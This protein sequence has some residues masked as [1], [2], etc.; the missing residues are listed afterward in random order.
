MWERSV[1]QDFFTLIEIS[2]SKA[3]TEKCNDACVGRN[4]KIIKLG[5]RLFHFFFANDKDLE[6]ALYNGPWSYENH[7]SHLLSMANQRIWSYKVSPFRVYFSGYMRKLTYWSQSEGQSESRKVR[8]SD[9]RCSHMRD[10]LISVM[11]VAVWGI[12]RN[13]AL[14]SLHM[15]KARK[16]S[17]NK[18]RG[19]DH[20]WKMQNHHQT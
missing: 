12:L 19:W 6:R 16:R 15:T 3:H 8:T 5:K 18:V 9:L 13:L 20:V 10:C 17:S 7:P 4:L 11:H 1:W 2:I 14:R